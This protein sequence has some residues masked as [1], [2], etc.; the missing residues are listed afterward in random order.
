MKKKVQRFFFLYNK[1][2]IPEVFTLPGENVRVVLDIKGV[3]AWNGSP[4]IPL[5]GKPVK[6]IRT[7]LHRDLKKIRVVLDLASDG[8][9]QIKQILNPKENV[10]SLN[11]HKLA[12]QKRLQ[13]K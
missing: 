11:L 7:H 13:I 6:Q 4:V 9:H 8:K 12:T 3:N 1:F 5:N 10:Y 2:A